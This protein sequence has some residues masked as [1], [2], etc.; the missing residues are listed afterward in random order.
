MIDTGVADVPDLKGKVD[1]LWRVSGTT[2]AQPLEGNDESATD[3]GR[4]ADRGERRRRLRHGRL[5][6]SDARDRRPRR[7]PTASSTTPR[8]DRPDE[9]RLARRA[10]RQH[11]PRRQDPSEPI[12]LDAIHK[13]AADGVLLVAAAGNDKTA[14]SAIRRP[15]CS[16]R[17]AGAATASPSAHTSTAP[18]LLL[19]LGQHLSLVAPG[20]YGG[21]C[22]GVLVA[23]PPS[24]PFD[25]ALLPD[26]VA[27]EAPTTATS[28]GT[29]FAAPEVAGIAA[30]IWAARPEL[31]NYQV[32]DIIKQSARRDAD[33]WTPELG[34]GILDAGAALEL[35]TSRAAAEWAEPPSQRRQ[36]LLRRRRSGRRRGRPS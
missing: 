7:H 25:D 21:P 12:L 14:T 15:T 20:D 27:R 1:S 30:L 17:A 24:S 13:A 5:R 18:R 35:A 28:P 10:D 2:V 22:T 29:S 23:L 6:R 9:A 31:T 11:E 32:A 4:L 16:R 8:R 26:W 34:C 33:G 3:R 36:D 19:E